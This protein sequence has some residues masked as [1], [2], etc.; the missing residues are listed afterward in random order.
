MRFPNQGTK[1]A[2]AIDQ[3]TN[4]FETFKFTEASGNL[5]VIFSDGED[6]QVTLDGRHVDD[7]MKGAVASQIPVYLVR[8]NRDKRAGDLVPDQIWKPAIESTGGRFYA[9]A[10]EQDVLRAIQDID[11]RSPGKIEMNQYSTNHR[12]FAPF[13]LGAAALW[14]LA[15]ALKLTVPHFRA[16]P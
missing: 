12:R 14:S 4:L 13:A 5:M 7:I 9:A 11:R 10:N 3:A 15:L 1:I 16:F 8:T 6:T 2:A